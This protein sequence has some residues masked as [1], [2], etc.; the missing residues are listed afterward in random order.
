MKNAEDGATIELLKDA[1]GAGVGTFK[2]AQDGTGVKNFTIDFGGH[3]YTCTGPAVGSSGTQSQAFHL[4]W[5][6]DA[7]NNAK[8]TLKNGTVTA[9]KNSGVKMIIQNYCDLTLDNMVIDGSNLRASDYSL[10][11]NC[12][13]IT[14]KDTEIIAPTGGVAFDVYGGF[15]S[16][17]DVTVTLE[18]ESK[19]SGK[20]E[21]A[22]GAGTQNTNT[23]YIKGGSVDD[24]LSITDNEKTVVSISGG[25]FSSKVDDKY[26]AP[27]YECVGPDDEGNYTVQKMDSKLVVDKGNVEGT[28]QSAT[29]AGD[30][31]PNAPVTGD[32][33]GSEV[34]GYDVS[35]DLSNEGGKQAD[36]VNLT[37]TKETAQSLADADSLSVATDAGTV[38]LNALR[39]IRSAILRATLLSRFRRIPLTPLI[40][41]RLPT[42][43]PLRRAKQTCCPTA[44]ATAR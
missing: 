42:P 18:G 31:K 33:E 20:V 32:N 5:T 3:T 7:V 43:F 6:G 44:K 24:A 21:V 1:S 38:E 35:L 40:T 22:R 37:V 39:W 11:N 41:S 17:G 30:F 13:N 15:Q 12:G 8:V 28:T 23:L 14:I 16:Y 19:I 26:L 27:N 2:G 9:A 36:T 29:L 25:T 10:S 34:K 4:E